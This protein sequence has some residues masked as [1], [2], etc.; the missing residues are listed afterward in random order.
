[1]EYFG[2]MLRRCCLWPP[3][4]IRRSPGE[5]TG[6]TFK[7]IIGCNIITPA[8]YI[9]VMLLLLKLSLTVALPMVCTNRPASCGEMRGLPYLRHELFN[10]GHGLPYLEV[11]SLACVD[12]RHWVACLVLMN[13]LAL[14]LSRRQIRLSIR[15][16]W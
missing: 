10:S 2:P 7:L 13:L 9:L 1:M 5:T 6:C 11:C 15:S 4:Q 8:C 16:P 3:S 12:Q 14:L